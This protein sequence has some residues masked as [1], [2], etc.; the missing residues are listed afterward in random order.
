MN[1]ADQ[2]KKI[3]TKTDEGVVLTPS[4]FG[5]PKAQQ[6]SLLVYLNRLVANG[7]LKRL[8]R[9]KYYKPVNSMFGIL[10]PD[11]YQKVKEYIVK[12]GQVIGYITGTNAF[13]TLG[14]TTQ[15]S[16]VIMIGTNTY[17]RPHTRGIDRIAFVLQPNPIREDE[18]D[19]YVILD[20]LRFILDIPATTSSEA[21]D[22]LIKVIRRLPKSKQKRLQELAMLY[23]PSV[24]ALL[25]AIFER[26]FLPIKAL[27]KSLNG[28]TYYRL[29]ID[30]DVLPTK[31]KWRIK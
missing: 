9:G 26:L 21:V 30:N 27:K 14:L 10:P 19:L 1:I 5:V 13:A 16:G 24:R 29:H 20:A 8:S 7:K 18:I 11:T 28:T 25:G 22:I 31:S 6:P 2:I 12:D 3:L 15:I 17:R 23:K 4:D